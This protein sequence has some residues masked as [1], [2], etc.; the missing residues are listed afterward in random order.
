MKRRKT[1]ICIVTLIKKSFINGGLY[2]LKKLAACLTLS[3]VALVPFGQETQAATQFT[4][5]GTTHR[6]QTEITYLVEGSIV[7]GYTDTKFAPENEVTRDQAAAMLGRTLNL[8]GEQGQT[9]F[10][11]VGPNNS[12]SG[13]IQQLV[14][15]NI[16]SGYP[17]GEF[18]PK[19]TL[20][21]GEMAV[22]ISRTFDYA[23]GSV[24]V[25]ANSLMNKG[26]SQGV[27]DGS[28]GEM[29]TIKRADFAVFLARGIN[30][31]FRTT[32]AT[33]EK[34]DLDL[35]VDTKD[36]TD[37]NMR[38]G[39]GVN[40][41]TISAMPTGKIVSYA[42]SVGDWAYITSD[43]VKGFVHSA[44]LQTNKP[45]TPSKPTPPIK[46][47]MSDVT[48]VI[49]AGH[50][51]RDPGSA[52]HGYT[53][54][55][56]T[57]NVAK[58]ME[59]YYTNTPIKTKM[60]RNIDQYV[61]LENRA[62]YAS[63]INGDI[64]VSIHTNSFGSSAA[65][66]TETFYYGTAAYNHNNT[67]KSKALAIY[68]QNRMLEA[69]GLT[70]RGVK[71]GNLHVLRQ[72]TVPAVLAEL[73]F[74]TNKG[75]MGLMGTEAGRE[76]LARGLYLATLDY[77]YYVENRTDALSLYNTVNASPSGKLH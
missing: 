17:D 59:N 77:Y 63:K 60:T 62:K 58:K 9:K 53:E 66:G 13:Y 32:T 1:K 68:T 18:K 31:E 47:P 14:D 35:Y 45:V 21:R 5:V 6:A 27:A 74:I 51:G 11:D 23:T 69:W 15:K 55:A 37:L 67:A 57:L 75:D 7:N 2:Y 49:D 12:A 50:G 54:A 28:F 56:I 65:H 3:L 70:D 16:I 39:P 72:N 29:Q 26:I 4:D 33:S 20:T 40:F 76:K 64:F 8:N 71:P 42:Y 34:F 46:N 19:N 25:A 22:L 52:G 43:N 44:Y 10:N 24:S 41:K 73:G 38:T 36:G 30:E 48:I 61:P